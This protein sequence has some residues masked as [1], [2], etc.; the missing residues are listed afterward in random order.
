MHCPRQGTAPHFLRHSSGAIIL[1]HR[2]PG[3]VVYWSF[4]KGK[5]LL[6]PVQIDSVGGAYPSCVELSDGRVYCVY[7]KEGGGH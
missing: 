5:T 7:D 2:L 1:S 6:E 3:T 4:D